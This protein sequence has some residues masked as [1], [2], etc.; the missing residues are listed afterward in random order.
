MT[1]YIGP[2]IPFAWGGR[3]KG[4]CNAPL[5]ARDESGNGYVEKLKRQPFPIKERGS[6]HPEQSE[7]HVLSLSKDS[8]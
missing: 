2:H 4:D 3:G 1:G 7:E 5:G 6:C 8:A